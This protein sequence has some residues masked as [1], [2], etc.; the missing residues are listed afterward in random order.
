MPRKKPE[1]R[2]Q[3]EVKFHDM[4]LDNKI[5]ELGFSEDEKDE[6]K[7]T[8]KGLGNTPIPNISKKLNKTRNIYRIRCG[9]N[10][11]LIYKVR[12]ARKH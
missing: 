10:H 12:S 9:S 8:I 7:Q 4:T 3:Y 5:E 6:I 11:R 2:P 1:P